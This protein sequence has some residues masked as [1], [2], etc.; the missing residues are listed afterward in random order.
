VWRK[1]L[2][3]SIVEENRK[4]A[5]EAA[6]IA[7]DL[8]IIP[9]GKLPGDLPVLKKPSPVKMVNLLAKKKDKEDK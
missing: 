2:W 7:V 9:G 8:P 6:S 5:A 1:E 4:A 3:E